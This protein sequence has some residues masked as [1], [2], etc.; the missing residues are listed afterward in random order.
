[1]KATFGRYIEVDSFLHHLD[2]RAKILSITLYTVIIFGA[3]NFWTTALLFAFTF[4]IFW[5]TGV[6]LRYIF[7]SIRYALHMVLFVFLLHILTV[8]TGVVLWDFGWIEI[9]QAGVI[10]GFYMGVRLLIIIGISSILTITTPPMQITDGLVSLLYPF[11]KIGFPVH[12]WALM[13]SLALRFI[14]ML[15][16]EMNRIAEAQAARGLDLRLGT[17]SVRQRID[18]A[19]VFLIPLFAQAFRS[20][21]MLALAMD[22]RGY[23]TGRS[24][25]K[26]RQFH[27]RTQDTLV[28]LTVVGLGIGIWFLRDS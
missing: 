17:F 24:R 16:D 28:I 13:L 22:A 20:A 5:L 23:E 19:T 14:P 11:R 26:A 1:M 8:K 2:A 6:R 12:E 10:S 18:L 3:N 15:S 27:W 21:D 7:G 4:L 25:T 9:Y